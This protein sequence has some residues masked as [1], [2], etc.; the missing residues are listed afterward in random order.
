MS[1]FDSSKTKLTL[2]LGNNQYIFYKISLLAGWIYLRWRCFLWVDF[3]FVFNE[4]V[5]TASFKANGRLRRD[6][7]PSFTEFFF[8]FFGEGSSNKLLADWN[9]LRPSNWNWWINRPLRISPLSTGGSFSKNSNVGSDNLMMMSFFFADA[10][11]PR[12]QSGSWLVGQR[13]GAKEAW[14]AILL[15]NGS[16]CIR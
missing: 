6:L 7:V 13:R 4:L 9:R 8:S 15:V 11:W 3:F 14:S 10:L 5:G 1:L 2:I 12:N 16:L